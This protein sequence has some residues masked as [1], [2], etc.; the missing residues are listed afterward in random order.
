MLLRRTS[1]LLPAYRIYTVS[2]LHPRPVVFCRPAALRTLGFI[3]L[4]FAFG[5]STSETTQPRVQPAASSADRGGDDGNSAGNGAVSARVLLTKSGAAMLE[6][7]TGTFD[8]A[9]NTGVSNGYFEKIDYSVT[10]TANKNKKVFDRSISFKKSNPTVFAEAI[11]LC[12]KGNDDDDDAWWSALAPWLSSLIPWWPAPACAT[13]FSNSYAVSVQ[14]NLGGVSQDGKKTDVVR[15][16]APVFNAPDLDLSESTIQMLVGG[17]L[18]ALGLVQ[19]AVNQTYSVTFNNLGPGTRAVGDYALCSVRVFNGTTDVT[20]SGITYQ[21]VPDGRLPYDATKLG[22]LVSDTVSILPGDNAA[23]QFTM[24]LP[25]SGTYKIQVTGI[26]LYPADFDASNNTVTGTVT[27][28]DGTPVNPPSGVG[29]RAI[30][31]DY[32]FYGDVIDP[33]LGTY[34]PFLGDSAQSAKI[35]SLSAELIDGHGITGTFT[36]KVHLYAVDGSPDAPTSTRD[37][38]SVTWTGSLPDLVNAT[39][40]ATATNNCVPLSSLAPTTIDYQKNQNVLSATLC[41]VP[42]PG[43]TYASGVNLSWAPAALPPAFPSIA[44]ADGAAAFGDYI[45]WDT[46]LSFSNLVSHPV[47]HVKVPLTVDAEPVPPHSFGAKVLVH[48]FKSIL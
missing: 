29:L 2:P 11:D 19:K 13:P 23:C 17:S 32:S 18:N 3:L 39:E 21:W 7:R 10:D 44:A 28:T 12:R 45:F 8:N 5:C 38:A 9:H 37:L 14:A 35:D 36:L 20:P 34:G 43:A 25:T 4:A 33:N 16:T 22:G 41:L 24:A 30:A 1:R 26:S 6:M 15:A 46:D 27:I 47:S 42:Q 40:A 48:R 31:N